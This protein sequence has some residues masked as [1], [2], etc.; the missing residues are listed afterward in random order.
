MKRLSCA[1]CYQ[2]SCGCDIVDA[3]IAGLCSSLHFHTPPL[4]DAVAMS[5]IPCWSMGFDFC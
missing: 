5:L 4:P 1:G 2:G 3:G